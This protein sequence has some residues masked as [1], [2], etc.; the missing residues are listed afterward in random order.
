MMLAFGFALM[1][2]CVLYISVVSICDIDAPFLD[3]CA[4]LMGTVGG[5]VFICGLFLL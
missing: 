4:V 5:L 3:T 1:A 2:L